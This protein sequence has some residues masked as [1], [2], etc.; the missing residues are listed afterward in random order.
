MLARCPLI[1][2][3]SFSYSPLLSLETPPA[4][5]LRAAELAQFML[6]QID[7]RQYVQQGP[8]LGSR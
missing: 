4:F 2:P 7:S 5:R 8:F 1:D 6:D 3:E